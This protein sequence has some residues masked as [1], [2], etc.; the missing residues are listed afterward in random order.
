MVPCT[1]NVLVG[2]FAII[3]LAAVVPL[4]GQ[5]IDSAEISS[6]VSPAVVLIKG[7]SSDGGVLGSGIIISADGK[8][9]T[10]LHVLRGLKAAGVQLAS[11]EIFDSVSIL[12]FDERKDIALIKVA[13]FDL[14]IV[15]LGNSNSVRSGEPV[16]V[17]GSPRGLQ[18]SVTTGVVSAIR[19]DP[20][21]SG[22]KVIQSDAAANP[23]NSGGPLLNA[24]GQ[25]IGIVTAKLRGA[26][27]LN[28][29]IPINYVRGLLD[30]LQK[31]SS[32]DELQISLATTKPDVFKSS[33]GY[34]A[35]W[36]SLLSGEVRKLRFD[37]DY[38]YAETVRTDERRKLGFDSYELKKQGDGYKGV[39]RVG[40]SCTYR[41]W[42]GLP[43]PNQCSREDKI[44]FNSVTPNR[45]E[46]R[47][48]GH[49][50]GTKLD[51]KKCTYSKPPA[52]TPFI[53]IPE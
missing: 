8:I 5:S 15:E 28:F 53:W 37:G 3:C 42:R 50:P 9:A 17:I 49:P 34:P 41:D 38:I 18:G 7:A 52:W 12:A 10:N 1:R 19:D 32:L 24:R 43:T 6:K 46:G 4:N 20:S 47:I 51:C 33:E 48:F 29:A 39:F 27:G 22:F 13:G 44:E 16:V 21:G 23:G 14:P 26:E 36:K 11:G 30:N 45:I 40:F 35:L 31:P 2:V 25:A